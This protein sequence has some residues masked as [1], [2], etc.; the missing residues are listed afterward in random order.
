MTAKP[1]TAEVTAPVIP[2]DVAFG[3][4]ITSMRDAAD[5]EQGRLQ[6]ERNGREAFFDREIA[7]M[8][9]EWDAERT[10]L[11]RQIA[12]Q[13]AVLD[14]CDAALESLKPAGSNV[15]AIAAE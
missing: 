4:A 7:R 1:K 12:A 11:D 15:V 8:V 6:N 10:S 5:A 13:G 9:A 2:A 14:G 3:N